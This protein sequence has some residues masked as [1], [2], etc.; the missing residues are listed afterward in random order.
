MLRPLMRASAW[1]R[2]AG[3]T[4]LIISLPRQQLSTGDNQGSKLERDSC[5]SWYLCVIFRRRSSSRISR[6]RAHFSLRIFVLAGLT[7]SRERIVI[8]DYTLQIL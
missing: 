3:A 2:A 5:L 6:A 7:L 1:I 4:P 8:H